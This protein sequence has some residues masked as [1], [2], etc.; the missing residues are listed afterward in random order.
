[1][2]GEVAADIIEERAAENGALEDVTRPDGD[3]EELILIDCAPVPGAWYTSSLYDPP[4]YSEELP[5]Q[6]ML[7]PE[8]PSGAGPPPPEK[9]L[10]QSSGSVSIASSWMTGRG[11]RT[12]LSCIFYSSIS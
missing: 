2:V 5:L 7:H 11:M 4:Q 1:M 12:A 10:P 8:N 9:E 6:G 3:V